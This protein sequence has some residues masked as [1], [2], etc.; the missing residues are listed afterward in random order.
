M[1]QADGCGGSEPRRSRER[2][3]AEK[4][5][6]LATSAARQGTISCPDQ[7]TAQSEPSSTGSP[8]GSLAASSFPLVRALLPAGLKAQIGTVHKQSTPRDQ[9]RS[10]SG[11]IG[12]VE[13]VRSQCCTCQPEQVVA[14]TDAPDVSQP[15]DG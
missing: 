3:R 13:L 9:A 5:S 1:T 7:M 14:S 10:G 6:G 8:R 4:V 2:K 12:E 11:R 15:I